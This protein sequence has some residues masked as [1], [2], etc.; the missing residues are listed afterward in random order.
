MRRPS[1][2]ERQAAARARLL[3]RVQASV[4]KRREAAQAAERTRLY[5][6]DTYLDAMSLARLVDETLSAYR[7]QAPDAP[8]HPAFCEALRARERLREMTKDLAAM[9]SEQEEMRK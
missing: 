4:S 1:I 8:M 2:E 5:I 6:L 3:D 9:V 7:P